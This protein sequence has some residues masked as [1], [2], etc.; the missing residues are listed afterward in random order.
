MKK[1]ETITNSTDTYTLFSNGP[2]DFELHAQ[3]GDWSIRGSQFDI[4][5]ELAEL[6]LDLTFKNLNTTL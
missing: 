6:G 4:K 2:N 5:E 1:L 3:N